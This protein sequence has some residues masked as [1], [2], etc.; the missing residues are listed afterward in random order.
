MTHRGLDRL[1]VRCFLMARCR[2]LVARWGGNGLV[3]PS[4]RAIY[5]DP[6]YFELN[7]FESYYLA[8]TNKEW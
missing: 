5:T 4:S 8:M 2:W 6:Y 7:Y 3:S 1:A